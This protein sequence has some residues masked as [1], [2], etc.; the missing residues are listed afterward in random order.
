MREKPEVLHTPEELKFAFFLNVF[1]TE[2]SDSTG[3]CATE[4]KGQGYLFLKTK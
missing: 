3:R 4:L 1:Q 2:G